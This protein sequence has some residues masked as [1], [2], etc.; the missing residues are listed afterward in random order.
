MHMVV[1]ML[2]ILELKH[3]DPILAFGQRPYESPQHIE[4]DDTDK[5]I[6]TSK[7]IRQNFS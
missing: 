6:R 2:F 3:L 1:G 7:L 4:R 5:F